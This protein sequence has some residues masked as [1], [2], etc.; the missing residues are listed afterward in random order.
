MK[1]FP[2]KWIV[3]LLCL[4]CFLLIALNISRLSPI[5]EA[6]Y[7]AVSP[8]ISPM[9]TRLAL[10]M[11]ALVSPIVLLLVTLPVVL[12]LP[13]KEYRAPLFL[14][15]TIAVLLNL[16]LKSVFLRPRPTAVQHLA[17]ESGF[18]FPSGHTMAATCF[19]GFLIYLIWTLATNKALRNALCALLALVIASVAASRVYLGVH[20]FTDVVAGVLV[21]TCYLVVF[22]SFVDRFFGNDEPLKIKGVAPNDHNRLLFSFSYAIQGVIGGLKSERNMVIHCAA[23]ATVIV[24]G[25]LL[26]IST[27]EWIACICLFGAVFMAELM[28]TAV[29]TVVDMVC[30]HIDPRAKLAKDAAAGA[31]L[32]MAVAAALVSGIIFVPKLLALL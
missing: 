22:T 28:N 13:K 12:F 19:Y 21:S 5:D 15:L 24:F 9:M 32:C 16:G 4:G 17:V 10:G 1:K 25:V 29:E 6:V 14:N 8:L 7:G 27:T 11:T 20:Y 18:S 2:A 30:P 23:M 26:R 3:C 31:V